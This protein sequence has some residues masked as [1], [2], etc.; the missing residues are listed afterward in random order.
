MKGGEGFSLRGYQGSMPL[1]LSMLDGVF[2]LREDPPDLVVSDVVRGDSSVHEFLEPHL[3]KVVEMSLHHHPQTLDKTLPGGG[4]CLWGGFCPHGH[5][6][7]PAWLLHQRLGGVLSREGGTWKVGSVSLK[8]SLMPG[9]SGRLVLL[10]VASLDQKT[11]DVSSTATVEDLM[12][13]ATEMAD[14]LSSLQKALGF[15]NE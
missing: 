10:D 13:E 11:A 2:V 5:S 14:L 3:D 8:L 6:E 4:S 15:K 1:P 7:N 9:H 12:G